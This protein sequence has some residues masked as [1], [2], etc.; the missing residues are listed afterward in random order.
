MKLRQGR[1]SVF[2][3]RVGV[4]ADFVNPSVP[5]DPHW[6][7]MRLKEAKAIYPWLRRLCP[8][9]FEPVMFDPIEKKKKDRHSREVNMYKIQINIKDGLPSQWQTL[10][11]SFNKLHEAQ[12]A[13]EVQEYI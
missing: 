10:P 7:V 4:F 6:A 12:E 5:D 8:R 9:S 2:I 11:C 13:V 3:R 1:C